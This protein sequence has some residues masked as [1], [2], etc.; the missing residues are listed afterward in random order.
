MNGHFSGKLCAV[1]PKE[2]VV[3]GIKSYHS[4]ED[5]PTT[6]L[7]VIAIAAKYIP[8]TVEILAHKK[9]TKAFIIISAGFSEESKDGAI[10]EQKIVET[11]NS[12]NGSL[13]GPNCTGVLTPNYHGIF[14]LPIPKLDPKGCDLISGSGA[15]ACFILESAIPKGLTFSSVISVGNSAQ[16]GVEEVLQYMDKT[17]VPNKDSKVKLLYMENISI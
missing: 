10:L 7:A 14:T 12:V 15:T 1:N 4:C 2:T 9:Q 13:I 16:M 3:Q 6:D 11:V 17:F 8:Q 5:I